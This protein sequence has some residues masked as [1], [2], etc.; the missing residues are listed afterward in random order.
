[1]ALG[2]EK[3]QDQLTFKHAPSSGEISNQKHDLPMVS[4]LVVFFGL[5]PSPIIS[6]ISSSSENL[7]DILNL[8]FNDK[9]SM[10]LKN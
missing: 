4:F 7:V 6:L 5:Y 9:I 2:L 8:Y 3:I 10:E 1:M